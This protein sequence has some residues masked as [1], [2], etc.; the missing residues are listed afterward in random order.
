MHS[1][2]YP[3]VM[4]N[5]QRIYHN[6]LPSPPPPRGSEV[7]I[8]NLPRD[9]F[10]DE[11]IP[12]FSQVGPI[13]KFRLMMDFCG[14]NRGFG[15]ATYCCVEDAHRAVVRF[16]RTY[17]RSRTRRSYISVH[18]SLDN[19]RLFFGNVP[20]DT[21]RGEIEAELMRLVD[22]AVRVIVYTERTNPS[23]NRGFAFVEFESHAVA[24][25]ARRRMLAGVGNNIWRD[26]DGKHH[27]LYVD[28]A[29]PEPIVDPM[30]LTE[31]SQ[32]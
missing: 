5:G 21:A 24:A 27:K 8:G 30:V 31:V 3:I 22:G 16:N 7:F 23:R 13:Y 20:R 25:I 18:V 26:R 6:P 4:S 14:N 12:L 9:L 2:K 29:E 32:W 28:W 10:E 15:F 1:S 17:V 11:L 19:C